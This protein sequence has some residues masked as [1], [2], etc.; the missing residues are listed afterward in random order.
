MNYKFI[1]HGGGG[2]F[3]ILMD[4]VIPNAYNLPDIENLYLE[5]QDN[6]YN[7]PR[8]GFNFVLDQ[9][10]DYS[11]KPVHCGFIGHI[12]VDDRVKEICKKFKLKHKPQLKS[13]LGVHYRGVDMNKQHPEYGVFTIDDYKNRIDSIITEIKP[14]SMFVASDNDEAAWQFHKWY[15]C[16]FYPDFIRADKLNDDTLQIQVENSCTVRHWEEVF[17]DMLTLSN[18]KYLL[19]RRSNFANASIAFSDILTKIYR[20]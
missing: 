11:F 14:E 10:C 2:I 7:C 19:C 15:S 16:K 3:S 20:L 4:L 6:E 17:Y 18:C 8:D 12:E 1:T 9:Y 13:D 5:I